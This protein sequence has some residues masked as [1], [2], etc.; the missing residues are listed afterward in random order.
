VR[1]TD[2][3]VALAERAALGTE[4]CLGSMHGKP[5]TLCSAYKLRMARSMHGPRS[6]YWSR[7]CRRNIHPLSRVPTAHGHATAEARAEAE[8]SLR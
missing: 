2:D 7:N 8:R 6:I 3:D 4:P 1:V 5:H